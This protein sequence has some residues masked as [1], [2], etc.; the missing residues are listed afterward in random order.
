MQKE[1][2]TDRYQAFLRIVE[3]GSFTRAAAALKVTQSAVSQ[4]VSALEEDLQLKLLN[5][6][7]GGVSLT[8]DGKALFPYIERICYETRSLSEH[9]RE[10]RGLET[11]TIR[12]GT[13]GSV[14]AHWLPSLIA[15]FQQHYPK[16][17]FT[18][19]Q[20]DY[21]SIA[22]WVRQGAADFG[23]VNSRAIKGLRTFPVKS[24]RMLAVL[25]PGHP[26][27][28]RETVPLAELAKERFILL[29]EGGYSEPLRA[30]EKEGLTPDIRYTIHDDYAIMNMVEAGL[31]VSM[32]A[33][34][35]LRRIDY[36]IAIRPTEPEVV[37]PISVCYKDR[38][39]LTL[40]A[41][42]FL[43]LLKENIP[44]LP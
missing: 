24:G 40:A 7:R 35:M 16:I 29:E 21:L 20:G 10:I 25:P 43:E 5:R 32:L 30:F 39:S 36:K 2:C 23:F 34:L 13:M 26:L 14:S 31:G 44:A 42:R 33:E 28:T 4:A 1:A 17:E 8:P 15:A 27:S 41:R 6:S 9:A 18:I 38:L 3:T 19:L 12:I 11:G 37:R 22:E